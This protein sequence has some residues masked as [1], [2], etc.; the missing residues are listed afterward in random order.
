MYS[1]Y[2]I[3]HLISYTWFHNLH[4]NAGDSHIE[5]TC[6]LV[7]WLVHQHTLTHCISVSRAFL[8]LPRLLIICV[9]IN[10]ATVTFFKFEKSGWKFVWWF[11][12]IKFWYPGTV[13]PKKMI[14]IP[15]KLKQVTLAV[16]VPLLACA[17]RAPPQQRAR[18]TE[19]RN[20]FRTRSTI[21]WYEHYLARCRRSNTRPGRQSCP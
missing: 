6:W 2:F 9:E 16:C 15:S 14:T 11:L 12:H 13:Y 18:C 19:R 17:V 7:H 4:T 21:F 5:C 1:R 10:L 20:Y 8:S 3:S